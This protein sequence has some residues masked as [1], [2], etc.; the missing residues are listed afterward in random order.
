MNRHLNNAGHECK[1]GHVKGR[2]I[3][4]WGGQMKSEYDGGNFYTCMK[5]E[6]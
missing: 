6:H 1:T 4:G 2:V 3:A 5:S